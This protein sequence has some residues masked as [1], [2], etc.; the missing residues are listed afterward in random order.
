MDRVKLIEQIKR[1]EGVR[2]TPYRCPAGKLSIGVG[3]NLDDVGISLEEAEY[4]LSRD[5]DRAFLGL[6]KSLPYFQDLDSVR[7]GVLVNMAFNLGLSG[8]LRFQRMLSA[9]ERGDYAGAAVEMLDSAWAG[10]VGGR[11]R[12]LARQ[13]ETGAW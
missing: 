7:Q 13:M 8:L 5:L 4:L 6:S 12:E 10:Q 2:L 1:H 3:R 9:V 11:A